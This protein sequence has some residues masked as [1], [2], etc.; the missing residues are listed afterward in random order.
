MNT[1]ELLI[2]R[3]CSVNFQRQVCY[4]ISHIATRLLTAIKIHLAK[5]PE[6]GGKAITEIPSDTATKTHVKNRVKYLDN[7]ANNEELTQPADIL[8]LAYCAKCT[9]G[10]MQNK[11]TTTKQFWERESGQRWADMS[12]SYRRHKHI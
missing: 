5:N 1:T 11:I 2:I 4:A 7:V 10:K 12:W 9:K 6:V 8:Q 3:R